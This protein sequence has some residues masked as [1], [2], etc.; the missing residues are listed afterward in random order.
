LED[1]LMR[2]FGSERMD[3]MLQRLGL[4]EGEAIVHPWVNK[5]LEKAQQKVEARNFEIRKN[6]LKYDNVMNDQ[7]K[8]IYE[9]RRDL[10]RASEISQTVADMRHEVIE[11]T[12]ARFVPENAYPEQWD[13]KGLHEEALRL[14]GID[15]P[16]ADWAKEEGIDAQGVRERILQAADRKMAEKA[17][18]FGP[19]VMR[20]AEKSLLLQLLDQSW[21]DHLLALDHLRHGIGLRA[22]GQRD[23][24]NEYKREAFEMFEG[25]LDRLRDTVTGVLSHIEIRAARPEDAL[26]ER[27]MQPMQET[28][29]DPALAGEPEMAMAGGGA[30]LRPAAPM[31]RAAPA[32]A[33]AS[34]DPGTW[35][36]TPRN[37]PCPCGS[38]KKYKHCH[39]KL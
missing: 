38:G 15:L 29:R 7:R 4:K 2:I 28:R 37:A 16:I 23:P 18:N 5:A 22:Y 1:D 30:A 33:A 11:R 32:G 34:A 27:R 25:M 12:V 9:Q 26:P 19:D 39:G 14:L 6:L 17:A 21:K 13:A 35:A 36:R 10:M 3:S 31:R 20:M 8:V 24:L